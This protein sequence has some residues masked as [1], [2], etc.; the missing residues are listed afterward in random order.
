MPAVRYQLGIILVWLLTTAWF[1]RDEI[2]P[3]T[4]D[5]DVGYETILSARKADETTFWTIQLDGQYAG[6]ARTRVHP[7]SDGTATIFAILRLDDLQT[8]A[9][10]RVGRQ[11]HVRRLTGSE[12]LELRSVLR[13]S[14][15]G[16][17]AAV[18]LEVRMSEASIFAALHGIADGDV[19][20]FR[21]EGL[22]E[23]PAIPR[24]F[25]YAVPEDAIMLERLAPVD[26]IPGLYQGRTW[27]TRSVNPIAALPGPLRWL[28]GG[29]P[30]E[31][32]RN[33]VT[34]TETIK[35]DGQH[36]ICH[37]IEHHQSQMIGRTWV[38]V[39]DGRVLR[40]TFR[41]GGM[42]MTLDRKAE[43]FH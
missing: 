9:R 36:V 35:L 22:D 43:I 10:R 33:R 29:E 21:V 34:G 18:D 24:T 31:V 25:D 6:Q 42:M 12:G 40:R 41:L 14:P 7:V 39:T 38:R 17:I 4:G 19:L 20:R 37:V 8:L 13:I 28:L 26:R 11:G 5:A 30:V 3:F 23:I 1:V 27:T 32:I 15:E 2:L 16:K